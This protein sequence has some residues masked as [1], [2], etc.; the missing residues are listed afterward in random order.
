MEYLR[1]GE[2]SEVRSSHAVER[3]SE[4]RPLN[5]SRNHMLG[6]CLCRSQVGAAGTP[7]VS[8]LTSSLA[9]PDRVRGPK[10]TEL[11]GPGMQCDRAH[12]GAPV[13]VGMPAL[14]ANEFRT[15]CMSAEGF[16]P[17]ISCRQQ[18]NSS[19][20]PGNGYRQ[21]GTGGW[22]RGRSVL[23]LNWARPTAFGCLPQHGSAQDG[24]VS[25]HSSNQHFWPG[26]LHR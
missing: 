8:R 13:E 26:R 19:N 21:H 3:R 17:S 5:Q 22:S 25:Y 4:L 9:R 11:A 7:R 16:Q 20:M 23:Q 6:S 10:T 2:E 14:D 24:D 1:Q 18:S 12:A 15:D